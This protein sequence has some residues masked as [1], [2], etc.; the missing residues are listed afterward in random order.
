M[1]E[2]DIEAIEGAI[3]IIRDWEQRL[4]QYLRRAINNPDDEPQVCEDLI[5]YVLMLVEN[6]RREV[7]RTCVRRAKEHF[8]SI[9]EEVCR[10]R[11]LADHS[12]APRMLWRPGDNR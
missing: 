12:P 9:T 3:P 8:K 5:N 1:D 6:N 10:S 7:A 11:A 4:S 2:L